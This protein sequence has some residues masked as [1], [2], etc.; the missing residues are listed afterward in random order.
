M[1]MISI[2]SRSGHTHTCGVVL[3]R[4]RVTRNTLQLPFF[5]FFFLYLALF[6]D[7]LAKVFQV[8]SVTCSCKDMCDQD[9]ESCIGHIDKLLCLCPEISDVHGMQC[10]L[11]LNSNEGSKRGHVKSCSSTTTN[12]I[13]PIPQC[14]WLPNFAG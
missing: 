2:L 9:R 10:A 6:L 14:L 12:I 7:A 4:L 5:L 1:N 13:S 8:S 3:L 11:D